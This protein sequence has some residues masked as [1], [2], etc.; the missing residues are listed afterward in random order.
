LQHIN[1]V[2]AAI[3]R[4]VDIRGYYHWSLLDN[5]EWIKG[6]WPRFGLYSVDYETL[7]RK[8]THSALVY[9]ELIEAHCGTAPNLDLVGQ[10]ARAN[11][12]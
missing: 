5:F 12:Y 4:G 8:P 6:F 9:R 10:V 3:H 1:E 2:A 7:E 11:G